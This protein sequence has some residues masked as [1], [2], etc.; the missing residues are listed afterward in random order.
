MSRHRFSF[1]AL[2]LLFI[3]LICSDCGEAA[4]SHYAGLEASYSVG[5]QRSP[6]PLLLSSH[7]PISPTDYMFRGPHLVAVGGVLVAISGALFDADVQRHVVA[8]ELTANISVSNGETWTPYTFEDDDGAVTRPRSYISGG[9]FNGIP[10]PFC[11]FV[12]G[13]NR[14][15]GHENPHSRG[16]IFS[17]PNIYF[18]RAAGSERSQ[19]LVDTVPMKIPS[20]SSQRPDD[21]IGF[22]HNVST[23]ITRMAD[24]TLVFPVQFLTMG[25]DIASTV[26]YFTQDP[27]QWTLARSASHVGCV[28]PTLLE[29][30]SGKL[31]MMASCEDGRRR[32]YASKDK[33][34][35][36]DG[37][38]LGPVA[39]VGHLGAKPTSPTSKLGSSLQRLVKRR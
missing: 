13:Y 22:F 26:M 10:E 39:R 18:A 15:S 24:G 25:R 8:G 27:P 3:V 35:T 21:L 9:A 1:A 31:F 17:E 36:V 11:A 4:H 20:R 2:L 23:P 14:S 29:W 19:F 16:G 37:G 6:P 5:G 7:V 28:N 12:E 30:E 33:G 34:D 32:V 38:A